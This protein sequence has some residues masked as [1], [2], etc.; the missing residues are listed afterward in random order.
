MKVGLSG[1]TLSYRDQELTLWRTGEPE[2]VWMNLDYSPVIGENG[3]PIGVVAIVVETTGKV[4]AERHLQEEARQRQAE[5]QRQ[6]KLFEQA[7]GFIIIMRGPEHIVEFVNRAHDEM[8]NSHDWIGR[9][10][11]EA[12]PSLT[13]QGYFKSLDGVYKSGRTF[14]AQ[15]APVRFCRTPDAPEVTHFLTFIYAPLYDEEEVSGIFCEGF[16]VTEAVLGEQRFRDRLERKVA[17]RTAALEQSEKSIRTILETSHLNQGLLSTDGTVVYLNAT[18]LASIQSG[19]SDVLGRPFWE[20][21]WFT[22]TPGMPQIVRDAVARV[23]KGETAHVSMALDMPTGRRMYDFSMRPVLNPAGEVV[24]LVPEAV[25]TTA[26]VHTERALQ[27][28]LKVEAIGNLTGGIA[29]D[30]NNLLMAILSSLE[31]LR[32]RLAGDPS[33]LRLVG[34]ALE[35]ARR[36]RSLTAR[37]LAFARKQELKSERIHLDRLVGGMSELLE[38]SLGPTV[39]V[40]IRMQPDLPEVETDPNQ[41]EAALLNLVLNARDAMHGEGSIVIA[42]REARNSEQRGVLKPGPYVCLSVSDTGEGMDDETLRRATEPFF[43]TKGVGKGTGLGLSMVHGIVEQSGG[44]LVLKSSPGQGT[45]AEI[46]LPALATQAGMAEIRPAVA[47]GGVPARPFAVEPPARLS[48]LA[49]D[50]DVLVLRNMAEMMEDLGHTVVSASSAR[51]ALVQLESLGFDLMITD[52]AMPVMTGTQLIVE[53]RARHPR[54]PVILATGYA[55]LPRGGQPG[56]HRLSKPFSQA[57]L[58]DALAD[59]AAASLRDAN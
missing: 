58:A 52:H 47:A 13:G 40:D 37:M 23:A 49:V 33:L 8:F 56:V 21:P 38:R 29:H 10:I 1:G 12:F 6:R 14:R 4:R 44:S 43:T 36:G 5:Q 50:D 24:A 7:P 59:V 18:A 48:I 35:G 53:A 3:A 15:S 45:R 30:F 11:R 41:L 27:Q 28:A 57:E 25:E 2:Q 9:P 31:L 42:A 22:G 51:E 16:D 17:E 54:L 55:E 34:T 19:L 20:T 32:K 26:R 39:A 46:W